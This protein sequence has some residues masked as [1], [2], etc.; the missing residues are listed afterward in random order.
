M[1][2]PDTIRI[3][4]PNAETIELVDLGETIILLQAEEFGEVQSV[5]IDATQ[6]LLLLPILEKIAKAV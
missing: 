6:A 4:S 3:Q 1:S 5:T 2:Q